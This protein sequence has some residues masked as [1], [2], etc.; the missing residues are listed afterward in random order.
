VAAGIVLVAG[1]LALVGSLTKGGATGVARPDADGGEVAGAAQREPGSESESPPAG[2]DA[3]ARAAL[4]AGGPSASDLAK[5]EGLART[6]FLYADTENVRPENLYR[7]W[8]KWTAALAV[9]SRYEDVPPPFRQLRVRIADAETR[10]QERFDTR[11]QLAD[12]LY[13]QGVATG[14]AQLLYEALGH[15][16]VARETVPD[17]TDERFTIA[18]ARV[19][20]AD[21][22][23][24]R[25]TKEGSR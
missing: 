15:L 11:I 24:R 5:A 17:P 19:G 14:D 13:E 4:L 23:W 21:A 7:A 10:I 18:T 6:G 20:R 3:G 16:S 12:Q 8:Q 1:A 25:V 9:V 2:A 22:A